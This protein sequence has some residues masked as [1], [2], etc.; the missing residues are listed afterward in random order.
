M[1]DNS[2]NS[3]NGQDR[4][5]QLVALGQSLWLDDLTRDLIVGGG[6]LRMIE[7]GGIRGMTS[8]P[9]IFQKAISSGNAYDGQI[10]DLLEK[11]KP[12]TEIFEALAV[13]D[14]QA[15]CDVFRPLYD[16]TNGADGFVSIEVSPGA[17]YSTAESIEEARR[18][19]LAV[20]RPNV[21][22]KIPGTD[23][24]VPAIL[25]VL[26]EGINV[27]I[28]LLFSLRNHKNVML[29]YI[30]ALEDRVANGK[31]INQLASVAS[32]FVSR[33]DTLIDKLLQDKIDATSDAAH[34]SR[35][36]ALQGKIAIANAKL[37]YEQFHDLF[38]SDRFARLKTHGARVQ[39][40]LWAS[41]GTKNPAYRDV[42]YVEE[43]IGADTVN[44]LPK[45]TLD[46]FLDHGKVSGTVDQGV[47]EAHKLLTALKDVGIDIDAVTKQLEDE[48]IVSFSKSYDSLIVGIAEK[49]KTLGAA[50]R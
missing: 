27:N 39:R 18:L 10:R 19:W 3:T 44:T 50:Q 31:P 29:A 23:E 8:N 25:Q 6:L 45:N 4:V 17:A 7:D 32:F 33:V 5:T 30:E 11:G 38:E 2:S 37:A 47:D 26:K 9:T 35:L 46:A 20:N 28:T 43:L 34:K 49:Q 13:Q 41:T 16:Q 15:A 48:G 24:G 12:P 36:A 40:P 14:V 21:M 1:T 42:I 22:I